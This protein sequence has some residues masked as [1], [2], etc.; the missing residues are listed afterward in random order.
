MIRSG[1]GGL[2]T[3]GNAVDAAGTELWWTSRDGTSWSAVMDYPPL[4]ATA[5]SGGESG[6]GLAANGWV[7]DDGRRLLALQWGDRTAAWASSGDGQWRVLGAGSPGPS[8]Q[9]DRM[10]LLPGGV[11]V[12]TATGAWY[13]E[14]T[15]AEGG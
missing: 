3:Q 5:C 15:A 14:A 7:L 13:G 9:P 12:R 1:A 10:A 11:L 6:C 2:L 8:G 4:G